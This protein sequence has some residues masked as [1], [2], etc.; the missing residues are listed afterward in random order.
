MVGTVLV[1]VVLVAAMTFF[2]GYRLG[3]TK[4]GLLQRFPSEVR[5]APTAGTNPGISVDRARETGATVGEKVAVGA[6]RAGQA[7]DNAGQA[8][9][10][11]RITAK[12]KSKIALDDTLSRSDVT[13]STDEHVVTLTGSVQNESQRARAMALARETSGVTSVTDRVQIVGVR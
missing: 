11:T 13:V 3:G 1:V 5:P 7:I 2:L 4:P 8:L 9:D 6:E 10:D 12:V